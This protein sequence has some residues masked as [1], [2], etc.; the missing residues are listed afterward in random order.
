MIRKR[1]GLIFTKQGYWETN[2]ALLEDTVTTPKVPSNNKLPPAMSQALHRVNARFPLSHPT[3]STAITNHSISGRSQS[4][5]EWFSV[6]PVACHAHTL[7]AYIVNPIFTSHVLTYIRSHRIEPGWRR[8][9]TCENTTEKENGRAKSH[10]FLLTKERGLRNQSSQNF[11]HRIFYRRFHSKWQVEWTCSRP[12][13]QRSQRTLS[14]IYP[15]YVNSRAKN[16][17]LENLC[18]TQ[19]HLRVV[20][21]RRICSLA[22]SDA[23][24]FTDNLSLPSRPKNCNIKAHRRSTHMQ[25][26]K[27]WLTESSC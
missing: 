5:R 18:C 10:R 1:F 22:R 13:Q 11:R 24:L 17:I 9:C 12:R 6:W 16:N 7:S 23:F 15:G 20:T 19:L 4:F 2:S 26:R 27:R 25:W 21:R 8:P 3:P 14:R